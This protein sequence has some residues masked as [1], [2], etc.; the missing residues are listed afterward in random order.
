MENRSCFS[1]RL[2][3]LTKYLEGLNLQ[4]L[5]LEKVMSGKADCILILLEH[6]PVLTVGK[7]GGR[8]NLLVDER[9]LER[10]GVELRNT[11]RGGNITY[12]GPGQVVAYPVLNLGKWKKDLPWYVHSLEEVVIRVLEDY[13]I[14]AGR[15]PEYRGVWVKETKIAA[16]GIAVKRW[17]TMHGFALN[18]RVNKEHFKLIN[19]CG[20]KD[21]TIASM[22]DFVDSV[23]LHEIIE[24]V[25]EKFSLVFKSKLIE[26][27]RE[28]LESGQSEGETRLA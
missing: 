23:D 1:L 16:V 21:Y 20:I 8:E 25:E 14:E 4:N 22:D 28:W 3:G 24:S 15:K 5:A 19:P 27:S 18:V 7:S 10:L 17:F 11:G 6:E 2:D 13:G 26:V 9:E 12:H